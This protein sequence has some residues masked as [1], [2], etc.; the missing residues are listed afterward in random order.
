MKISWKIAI[1][2]TC[3]A[4]ICGAA[5]T[6]QV[7]ERKLT[8]ATRVCRLSA[9]QGN[10]ESQSELAFMYS[11]GQG[12]PKDYAEALRWYRKAADQ[13]DARGQNGIGFLYELGQGVSQDYAEALHWYRKAADQGYAKAQTNIGTIYYNGHGVPQDNA[14][15]A[16]WYRKAADQGYANAQ[17][18]LGYMCYH[19]YGVPQDRAE[20][21]RWYHRASNQGDEK[22]QRALGLR[23]TGLST[24][25]AIG[26]LGM[27]LYCLWLLKDSLLPG[28]SLQNR[29]QRPLILAELFGLVWVGLMLYGAYGILPSVLVANIFS[30]AKSY[31]I[32][33]TIALL[34]S[35]IGPRIAKAALGVT[36]TLFVGI[37]LLASA[38]HDLTRIGTTIL[39]VCPVS[40]L[41]VGISATLAILLWLKYRDSG[42]GLDSHTGGIASVTP[43]ES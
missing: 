16:R 14:E 1:S 21:D 2:V 27:S 5:I 23:G 29:Q 15:A 28:R 18:D 32:G 13:G 36:G 25:S 10:A 12:V 31:V 8:E 39:A 38:H 11:H 9:E 42:R 33:M 3:V 24:K 30:F 4:L 40:G 37:T 20:A 19:G 35:G 17:Y 41:F 22:A 7:R 43:V 26:L 6:W 34:I